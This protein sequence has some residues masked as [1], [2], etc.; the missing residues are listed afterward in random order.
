MSFEATK[1]LTGARLLVD[2]VK[3]QL[4]TISDY[5]SP[6][7][8]HIGGGKGGTPSDRVSR[9]LIRKEEI[10]KNLT[11]AMDACTHLEEASQEELATVDNL[12]LRALIIYRYVDDMSWPEIAEKYAG[13]ITSDAVKKRFER[14]LKAY[15]DQAVT[16]HYTPIALRAMQWLKQAMEKA[17]ITDTKELKKT[18]VDLYN[19][20]QIAAAV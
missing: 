11:V 14:G 15:E 3:E 10:V 8:D 6:A 7:F 17:G 1:N 16:V 18:S 9:M 19:E 4:K 13:R 12:E 2:A 5:S 20:R